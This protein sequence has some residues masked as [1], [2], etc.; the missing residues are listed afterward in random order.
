VWLVTGA[1]SARHKLLAN[2]LLALALVAV[3]GYLPSPSAFPRAFDLHRISKAPQAVKVFLM[4]NSTSAGPQD[5]VGSGRA[6]PIRSAS[7]P[8]GGPSP[9][10][11]TWKALI[12][13][14][15]PST[16][17]ILEPYIPKM[18]KILLYGTTG[19]GKSAV[20]W[21]MAAKVASGEDF[22]GLPVKQTPV[23]FIEVDSTKYSTKRRLS[24]YQMGEM[25]NVTFNFLS[26]LNIPNVRPEH[27]SELM[28]TFQDIKPGLVIVNSLRKVHDMDDKDS[29][30]V[31]IV[32]EWFDRMFPGVAILF[33][34]HER[35]HSTNPDAVN[36]QKET[37]SGAM[38]WLNDAQVGLHLKGSKDQKATCKLHHVKS[39]ETELYKPLPLFL[40]DGANLS[41]W[42]YE[43]QKRLQELLLEGRSARFI[44]ETL[45][46]EWNCSDRTARDRRL[47]LELIPLPSPSWLGV[48]TTHDNGDTE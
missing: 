33:I 26:G 45:A 7:H 5:V 34:H 27:I 17:F 10:R 3:H 42:K 43:E 38:N 40:K 19:I 18:G 36:V 32:Y 14:D 22:F 29:K 13:S 23:Q 47:K 35:K 48:Q 15:I 2:V 31:K 30:T 25:P 28:E 1:W 20:S 37:F 39:Q 44:D 46:R 4:E 9:L 6:V 24:R 12:E 21:D 11:I 41:C 16:E 8:N